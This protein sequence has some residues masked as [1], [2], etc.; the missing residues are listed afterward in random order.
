MVEEVHAGKGASEASGQGGKEEGPFGDAPAAMDGF[1]FVQAVEEKERRLIRRKARAQVMGF[2]SILS[3][4]AVSANHRLFPC[5]SPLPCFF[6]A[7]GFEV[8]NDRLVQIIQK[9]RRPGGEA[10]YLGEA[11]CAAAGD[12]IFQNVCVNMVYLEKYLSVARRC[13]CQMADAF[14]ETAEGKAVEGFPRLQVVGEAAVI[15]L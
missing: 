14:A 11:F 10:G 6:A 3:A 7:A 4:C 2:S 1:P 13:L 9:V 15:F 5:F 12:E 8:L